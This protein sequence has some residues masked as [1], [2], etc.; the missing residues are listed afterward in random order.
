MFVESQSHYEMHQNIFFKTRNRNGN[1][2]DSKSSATSLNDATPGEL[3]LSKFINFLSC[4]AYNYFLFPPEMNLEETGIEVCQ[5]RRSLDFKGDV[6]W[7]FALFFT[8]KVCWEMHPTRTE[9]KDEIMFDSNIS[10]CHFVSVFTR[11][12][13][14][15]WPKI[16]GGGSQEHEF[17]TFDL[18]PFIEIRMSF[19]GPSLFQ[20]KSNCGCW[21]CT[22]FPEQ[23]EDLKLTIKVL[24]RGW[25]SSWGFSF[26]RKSS[27]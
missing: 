12:K 10:C 9:G 27:K 18:G 15:S 21:W 8:D 23:W 6:S 16:H 2:S 25:M 20:Q 14:T 11:K 3:I 17:I 7:Q 4:P 26:W 24:G 19:S 1:S 22:L 5:Q 13:D